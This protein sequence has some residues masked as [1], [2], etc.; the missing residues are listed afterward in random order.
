M[1]WS[2][3][4]VIQIAIPIENYHFNVSDFGIFSKMLTL[5]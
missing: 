1:I 3:F 5:T 4:F 2:W